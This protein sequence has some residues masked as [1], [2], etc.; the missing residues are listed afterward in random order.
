M[1]TTTV[2]L[3]LIDINEDADEIYGDSRMIVADI[4]TCTDLELTNRVTYEESLVKPNGQVPI[5]FEIKNNSNHKIDQ[6]NAILL[7]EKQ[8]EKRI[9]LIIFRKLF[10]VIRIYWQKMCIF[11]VIKKKLIWREQLKIKDTVLQRM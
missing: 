2:A 10:L 9:H 7:D 3:N 11:L 6:F 5:S 4:S 8:K 1:A